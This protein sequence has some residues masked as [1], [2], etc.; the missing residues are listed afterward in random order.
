[1]TQFIQHHFVIICPLRAINDKHH[2][3]YIAQRAGCRTVHQPVNSSLFFDMQTW[4]IYKNG[5]ISTLRINTQNTV[6]RGLWFTR[7]NTDFLPEQ[8]IQ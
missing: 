4:R 8:F 6:T 7:C 5:L 1:M 3:L 2:H